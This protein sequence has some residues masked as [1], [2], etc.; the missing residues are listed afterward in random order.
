VA[1]PVGDVLDGRAIRGAV[2]NGAGVLLAV[3]TN[4]DAIVT[5]DPTDGSVV[6]RPVAL[7][8]ACAPASVGTATDLVQL[9]NGMYVLARFAAGTQSLLRLDLPSGRLTPLHVDTDPDDGVSVFLA[10]LA[11]VNAAGPD[12]LLAYEVNNADDIFSYNLSKGFARTE[13]FTN[14]IPSYNAGRGD[15]AA[16]VVV[17]G[18]DLVPQDLNGDG[19]VDATDLA[20]LLSAW[21]RCAGCAPDFNCSGAVDSED[22]AI[23]L[24][25][26]SP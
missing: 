26:W 17:F 10:G 4:A 25:A 20:A 8:I 13:L 15:L 16:S 9:P 5:I 6:G 18:A 19:E 21:G 22:L 3:D 1:T 12:V 23:L 11:T 2:V 24:G 7:T 14:I